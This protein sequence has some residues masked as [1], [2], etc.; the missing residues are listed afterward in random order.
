MR[1]RR[2]GR[3]ARAGAR[4]NDTE[5]DHDDSSIRRRASKA[6]P[7]RLTPAY[8]E[9]GQARA[10][11]AADHPAAY[12]VRAHRPGLR[13]RERAPGDDDLTKQ[14]AGEPL[15]ERIIVHGHVLDE[16][17]AAGAEHAGRDLAG[18]RRP[19]ATSTSSTSTRRR[20]IRISPA[21][22]ASSPTQKGY[23]RFITIKPGAYPWRNH[24]NAWRPAHIHFSLFGHSFLSR[25]VTQMYFPGDPLFPF[26]PIFNSVT[27]E[28]ARAAHGLVVRS[29]EHRAGM[30]AGLPLRHRAARPQRRRRWSTE[31]CPGITPSQTVGPFFPYGA[32]ARRRLRLERR[33]SATTWSRRTPRGERIRIEGRVLDGDGEPV[34]D[35][36][37][38][39][40]QADAAGRYAHPARQARAAQRR[41]PAA[42]AAAA[43]DARRPLR[44]RHDQARRGAG[45]ERRSCRRRNPASACSRAACCTHVV[46]AHLFR[47]RGGERAPIRS[48]RWCRPERRDDPDRQAR[49]ARRQPVY[50]FDI[51]LQGDDETVFFEV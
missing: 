37:I 46:Y 4:L 16:D 1:R 23:Y 12:A 41:V 9:H 43:T 44:L 28:K 3:L 7:P 20:S 21:P 33:R 32:D 34:P 30:G 11:A 48:S 24:P 22:A 2:P 19:A 29:G 10:E 5:Q 38:E 15:G 18:Q 49:D 50:R 6:I 14:H 17:G 39:I 27:D 35:A 42:S 31:R 26:D 8:R 51:R 45:P 47:R 40:W 25:L 13:P 36:M